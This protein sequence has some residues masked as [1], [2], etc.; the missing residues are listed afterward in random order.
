MNSTPPTASPDPSLQTLSF[1]EI[2]SGGEAVGRRIDGKVVFVP[3]GAPLETALVQ[4]TEE[5]KGYARGSLVQILKP[6]P[7]R[8][9]PP[10]PLAKT[11]ACGG[12]PLMHVRR[13]TQL[14]AKDQFVRRSL[15]HVSAQIHPILSPTTDFGYRI[16][17]RFIKR[18]GV[19]GFQA[20]RSHEVTPIPTCPILVPALDQVMTT[21]AKKL[22]PF[23]GE[24]GT[25][26]G[27][28]GNHHQIH[29][30]VTLGAGANLSRVGIEKIRTTIASALEQGLIVGATIERETLGS[31]VVSLGT[32]PYPLFVGAESFAQASEAGHTLLPTL[33][34][35][36]V[37]GSPFVPAESTIQGNP[38]ASLP[39]LLELHAGSGNFTRYLLPYAK[40]LFAVESE[41]KAAARLRETFGDKIQVYAVPDLTAVRALTKSREP[42]S[43]VVLDPPRIGAKEVMEELPKLSPKRIV[44]VSCDPMTLARDLTILLSKGYKVGSVIPMDLMPQTPHVEMI[45]IIEKEF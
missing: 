12:C 35:S 21:L 14:A 7:S 41:P 4:L 5:R 13:E 2:S 19:L 37:L 32:E 28:I 39:N 22:A 16:R 44:Y 1:Y 34:A 24:E 30:A 8:V 11:L 18:N 40:R 27:V 15:R 38:A 45:A 9:E 6:G 20:A 33:V 26:S 17:A 36:A 31:P 29:V 10:C 43:V 25:L 3:G 23:L 42:I